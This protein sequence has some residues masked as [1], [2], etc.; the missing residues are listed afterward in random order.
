MKARLSIAAVVMIWIASLAAVE[1]AAV[2]IG[3]HVGHGPRIHRGHRIGLRF[4]HVHPGPTVVRVAPIH[5]GSVDFN[6]RPQKSDIYVDGAYLGIADDFNG[7]PQTA[8][9]PVG[10]HTV[11]VVAPDGREVVRRIYVAPGR[12]LNF[13]LKF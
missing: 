8:K 10:Y 13:N 12:E 1:A 7:Y 4:A 6:V 11:R 9:L 5:Y 3:V 2:R